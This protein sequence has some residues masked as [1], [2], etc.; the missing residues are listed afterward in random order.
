MIYAPSLSNT[1][2]HPGFEGVT[3]LLNDWKVLEQYY[4]S[5]IIGW[6]N[7]SNGGKSSPVRGGICE[8][9]Q[10]ENSPV[11]NPKL[12]FD[13]KKFPCGKSKNHNLIILK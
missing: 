2:F 7:L 12:Q 4:W 9:F 11:A 1:Y 5:K 8:V 6:P 10:L 13:N 3:L